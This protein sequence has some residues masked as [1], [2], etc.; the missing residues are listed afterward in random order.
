MIVWS[1]NVSRL[2]VE[3]DCMETIRFIRKYKLDKLSIDLV[4]HIVLM[5]SRSWEV[6]LNHVSHN[7]NIVVDGM[8]R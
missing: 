3:S 4:P 2:V 8:T 7:Q 1:V 6:R 5:M